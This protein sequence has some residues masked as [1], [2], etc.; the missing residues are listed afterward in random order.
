MSSSNHLQKEGLAGDQTKWSSTS[1]RSETLGINFTKCK[2][3]LGFKVDRNPASHNQD[4]KL[5]ITYLHF[6]TVAAERKKKIRDM[7]LGKEPVM[8]TENPN[9]LLT[10]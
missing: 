5:L 7:M 6:L 10:F 1:T 4:T 3:S 2:P 8:L 9:L